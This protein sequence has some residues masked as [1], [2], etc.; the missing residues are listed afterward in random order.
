MID[1]KDMEKLYTLWMTP[2]KAKE[3]AEKFAKIQTTY[4]ESEK[5]ND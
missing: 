5:E 3:E 1:P 2:E 4:Y